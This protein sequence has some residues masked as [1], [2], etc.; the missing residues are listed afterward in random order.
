MGLGIVVEHCSVKFFQ[1]II[2]HIYQQNQILFS[3]NNIDAIE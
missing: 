3:L 2:D 1:H